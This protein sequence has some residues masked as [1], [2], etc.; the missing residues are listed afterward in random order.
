MKSTT[1]IMNDHDKVKPIRQVEGVRLSRGEC[2]WQT[3]RLPIHGCRIVDNTGR[4]IA[5]DIYDEG[6]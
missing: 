1:I 3:E 4:L 5:A 2:Y 6:T